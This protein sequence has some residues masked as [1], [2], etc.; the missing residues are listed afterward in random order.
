MKLLYIKWH[1]S[2]SQQGGIWHDRESVEKMR[3]LQIVT[4]GWIISETKKYITLASSITKHQ[5]SGDI[6][7]PKSCIKKIKEL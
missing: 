1:D 5:V 7:I 4:V 6:C 2:T 3:P